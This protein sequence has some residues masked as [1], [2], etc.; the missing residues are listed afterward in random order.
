MD[1]WFFAGGNAFADREIIFLTSQK[2]LSKRTF[3]TVL[4]RQQSRPE[5]FRGSGPTIRP[6]RRRT[7]PDNVT[8]VSC[9]NHDSFDLMIYY[10]GKKSFP[11]FNHSNHSSRRMQ[12]RQKAEEVISCL[13]CD[14]FFSFCLNRFSFH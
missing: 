1:A 13:F 7:S 9:L 14:N 3:R 8:T 6:L 4:F 11:S 5:S 10:D 12:A 2:R